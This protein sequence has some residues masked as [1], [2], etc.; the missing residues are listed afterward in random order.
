[1]APPA[2]T[3]ADLLATLVAEGCLR[4]VR[5]QMP[6]KMPV[7]AIVLDEQ[8]RKK[9]D[10]PTGALAV[11]YPVGETGV[12]MQMHG[13]HAR[14]WYM[15]VDTDGALATFERELHRAHPAATFT[16][17][18]SHPDVPGMNVRTYQVEVDATHFVSV[19]VTY[20]IDSQMKQQF[21]VRLHGRQ[22]I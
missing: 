10:I 7:E 6:E 11:F 13:A 22:R 2:L 14:I 15:G 21:I 16:V 12:F 20:P 8:H 9:L 18:R 5:G 19:E 1:M 17:Q 4:I 3:H